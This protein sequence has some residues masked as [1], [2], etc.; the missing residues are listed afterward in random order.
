MQVLNPKIDATLAQADKATPFES[1][2]TGQPASS[3]IVEYDDHLGMLV[4]YFEESEDMTREA[5]E[6]AERDRDY[7]DNDQ[8]TT[9]ERRILAKRKQPVLTINY[10]KTKVEIMRGIER[11]QRSDPKAF[12]RNPQDEQTAGAATDALRFVADQNDFDEIRSNVYENMIVEGFGGADVVV[13]TMPNGE[14]DIKFKR[15]PWDRLVYDPHS[16]E[17]DFSDAAYKG[18]VIWKDAKKEDEG[19]LGETLRSVGT[20]TYDDRPKSKWVDSKRQRVRVVQM[21]YLHDDQWMVA[22][23]TKGGFIEKPV[24]SPYKDKFGR[25]VSSLIMRS[26][27]VDRENNRYGD[28]R[29]YISIQD[30]INKRR[31]K[32]LHLM[33]QRQTFGTKSGVADAAKAKQ[34]LAKPDGH[35]ELNG[36]AVWMQD[37]GVLPTGDMAQGQI[38]LMQQAVSEMNRSGPNAALAGKAP[39][40]QS[41][42][43]LE[44]QMQGG[45]VE[46]EPL[47]D[48]LRQ[49][50]RDVYEAAWMR[51]RQ[52]WTEEKFVRVTDDDRNVKFVGLNKRVTVQDK[53]AQMQPEVRAM[54]MQQRQI[55]PN[56][57]RLLEVIEIEN[58]VSGLDVDIVIEEG[59]D[60]ATLQSEQFEILASLAEKGL[61]IP[62][63]AIVEASSLRNKDAILK[64]MRGEDDK[65]NPALQQAQAQIQAMEQAGTQLQQEL[66]KCKQQLADKHK[67]LL[68][69][70]RDSDTKELDAETKRIAAIGP[71]LTPE[72]IA[73]IV[74]QTMQQVIGG[75]PA[76]PAE[77][78]PM[79]MPDQAQEQPM[80]P[81]EEP[82]I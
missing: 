59:P 29:A 32:A 39:G 1:P 33:S 69:K 77:P 9:E 50:S 16:S 15:V 70:A 73:A 82:L 49:F 23:F 60:I 45:S 81:P 76:Q 14:L 41:G 6:L 44:A 35:V 46:I 28:V 53:L 4:R 58:E 56:D 24:V 31:S 43:A 62:P 11:R 26:A 80:L 65:Q 79:P 25:S 20:E 17:A 36:G 18:I 78:M 64:K 54:W 48:A 12:P 63:D 27:Y 38:A 74:M 19:A 8:W 37:F 52:F 61:A 10:I 75:P 42:R 72:D 13:E 67:E 34:E 47:A 30:E 71:A 66:A 22:T 7:Y 3:P 55:Q 51:V 5:R 2:V 68:I 40:Q 21:H 57:P